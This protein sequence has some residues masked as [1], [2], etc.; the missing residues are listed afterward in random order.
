MESLKRVKGD[1]QKLH[2]WLYDYNTNWPHSGIGRG[3]EE[4]GIL[5]GRLSVSLGLRLTSFGS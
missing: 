4:K 3:L 1:L 2:L 5:K